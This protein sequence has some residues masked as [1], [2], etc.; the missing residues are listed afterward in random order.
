MQEASDAHSKTADSDTVS[1]DLIG[2]NSVT[3]CSFA[4]SINISLKII[5]ILM[6]IITTQLNFKRY[7]D[8]NVIDDQ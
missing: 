5:F 8:N 2:R 4:M 7:V 3:V 6:S 1:R